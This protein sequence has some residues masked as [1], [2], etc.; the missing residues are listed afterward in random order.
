MKNR[1]GREKLFDEF[2]FSYAKGLVLYAKRFV[3]SEEDS[4]D[5]VHDVFV[6]FW[7]KLGSISN[8]NIRSYL[9][10]STRNRCL[11][12]LSKLKKGDVY[13]EKVIAENKY[14]E[15]NLDLFVETEAMRHI[16]R[17]IDKLPPQ[18]K[19]VFTMS[20]LEGKT[21]AMIAEELQISPKTVDKHLEM[22]IRSLRKELS[23]ATFQA[24]MF[25]LLL[26]DDKL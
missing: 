10:V 21:F 25:A 26:L 6:N 16:E 13:R 19:K 12:Q 2:F 15:E 7:E 24:L 1:P 22:A 3:G 5:I 18:R 11:D 23:G 17:A 8:D 20:K 4:K 9:F 14:L